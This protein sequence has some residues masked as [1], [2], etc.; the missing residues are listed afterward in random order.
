MKIEIEN[1]KLA[2]AINFMYGVKLARK[3]SRFRR[4]FIQQMS[5]RL[6]QVEEDRKALLEEHSHKDG[7]GKAIVKDGQY[8][9]KDMVA[10]SNDVKELNKEKLVIEGGDN[11]EMIRT[12]KVVLEKLEDEEYEGQDSEIY[13]YLCD[14]FKV[15]E[16]GEDQ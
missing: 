3:Q 12:I 16:E 2:A 1:G 6:K 9:V 15:D 14:Q 4:H 7:D 8:D 5:D 11:R 13:D 10:F